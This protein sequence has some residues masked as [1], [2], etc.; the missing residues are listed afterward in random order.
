MK[1]VP[2]QPERVPP[3]RS[4]DVRRASKTGLRRTLPY[5]S[6][7]LVGLAGAAFGVT[8]LGTAAPT[9]ERAALWVGSVRHGAMV[10]DVQGPGKLVPEEIRWITSMVDARV[11]RVSHKPGDEVQA[12]TVLVEL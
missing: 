6:L 11:E 1:P 8:R 5:V 7:G 10:R 3:R 4:M 2:S 12:D 9:V